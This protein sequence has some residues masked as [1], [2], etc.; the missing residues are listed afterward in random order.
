MVVPLKDEPR[1]RAAGSRARV[2][3]VEIATCV[4]ITSSQVTIRYPPG[5]FTT[6][7]SIAEK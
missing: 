5:I 4:A 2:A 3:F 7:I 6:L 1:A